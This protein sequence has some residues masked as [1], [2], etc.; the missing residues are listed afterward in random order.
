MSRRPHGSPRKG[1]R[2]RWGSVRVR[3]TLA[4][5]VITGA[6]VSLAGW[7]LVRSVEGDQIGLLRADASD[8]LDQVTDR[9]RAGQ[10]PDQV[11]ESVDLETG[12]V[13]IRYP[14]GT[15]YSAVA[16]SGARVAGDTPAGGLS[17]TGQAHSPTN[18]ETPAGPPLVQV[19]PTSEPAPEGTED[20]AP[21]ST[22]PGTGTGSRTNAPD[23]VSVE[24]V[25][26]TVATPRGDAT[27]A[28]AMPGEQVARSTHA[29]SRAL[30]IGLP[31][32]VGLAALAAWWLV[33]RALRPVENIRA[34]AD[35][36]GASTLHRRLPQP[37]TRD[38]I[39]RLA[40]TMNAM[41]DRLDRSAR[42]QRQFVADASHELRSP[43]AAIRTD[44]EVALHEDDRADWPAVA[45]GV[46][47]AE[48]RLETLL[49]DLL[50]L[51]AED[52]DALAASAAPVDLSELAA[53][54]SRRPRREPVIVEAVNQGG[55]HSRVAGP[56]V[57][58]SRSQLQRALANLVDN[59]ARHADRAIRIGTTV[60]D[61][62]V[63]LWVDDDGPGIPEADRE[64][65]FDR[66]TRLDDGRSRED[67]GAGLGLAVVRS[68]VTRH[69]GSVCAEASPLGGARFAV[70]LP[71][72]GFPP[73]DVT[74]KT[75]KDSRA[76]SEVPGRRT[77][78]GRAGRSR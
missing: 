61:T 49:K 55:G 29:I 58:G 54:E 69:G 10:P 20:D 1:G 37:P 78:G 7:M 71:R 28:V 13:E 63:R 21:S 70:R 5:A 24:P 67:G 43:V 68:I 35:A 22:E 3:I 9:L 76:A 48:T 51:A 25:V 39:G 36:I 60:D 34:E 45:R 57:T 38:E 18:R 12:V 16:A 26:R 46:L 27:V 17:R 64:R 62:T 31:V 6:A 40:Q 73:H 50:L 53:D 74:A 59:A 23:E 2:R 75:G 15:V 19:S 11:V 41:L 4:A 42:R 52:E 47:A 8:L 33:G 77:D 14:D 30:V 44:L 65:V 66:F 72:S 32:I 56:Q